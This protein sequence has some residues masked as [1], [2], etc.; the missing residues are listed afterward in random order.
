MNWLYS[1]ILVV[2]I[3]TAGGIIFLVLM[4]HG[5]GAD[6]GAAYGSGASGSLFGASGSA[7]FFSRSTAVLAGVFFA[8]CL[9]LGYLASYQPQT[10]GS[11]MQG[12]IQS[13]PVEPAG[14]SS[15]G[16]APEGQPPGEVERQTE[17][18]TDSTENDIPR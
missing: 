18:T 7:N 5:K 12:V 2:H 11:I 1:L 13:A 16:K 4:Q 10:S 3:L 6:I 9:G 17:Q 14:G 8:T 15:A